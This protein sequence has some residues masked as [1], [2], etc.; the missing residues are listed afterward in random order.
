M[1]ACLRQTTSFG[2][3]TFAVQAL[4][5]VG[6]HKVITGIDVT[7]SDS[8]AA[9]GEHLGETKIDLLVNNAGV[10]ERNR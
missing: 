4:G 9:L 8:L 7:N 2:T 3:H 1:G 10:L 6:V 5:K